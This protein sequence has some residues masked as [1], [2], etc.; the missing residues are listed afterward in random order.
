MSFDLEII[1]TFS[2][3]VFAF[4]PTPKSIEWVNKNRSTLPLEFNMQPY[5]LAAK[6]GE[7]CFSP[8]ENPDHV[9]YK[10]TV[11]QSSAS[12]SLLPV[13]RLSTI[14]ADLGHKKIDLLKMDIE[15][16]EYEVI[17]DMLGGSV[18]PRQILVEFHHRFPNIGAEKTNSAVRAL[19]EAGYELFAVSLS[20][21]EYGFILK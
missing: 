8:P 21:E 11:G 14:M 12:A 15:G 19:R 16:A 13:K 5:G 3:K 1:D 20:N 6:D 9:S 2:L 18:R 4:D 10:M 17:E 7:V